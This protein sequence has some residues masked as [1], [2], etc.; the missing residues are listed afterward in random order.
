MGYAGQRS[1]GIY[2]QNL[3]AGTVDFTSGQSTASVSYPEGMKGTPAV[4]VTNDNTADVHVQSRDTSGFT[5]DRETTGTADTVSWI[6]FND[7]E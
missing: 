7:R 3:Q 1:G 6:A 2:A 5:V 4:V